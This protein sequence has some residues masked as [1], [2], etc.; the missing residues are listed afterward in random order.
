[1]DIDVASASMT[2]RGGGGSD[3]VYCGSHTAAL[4]VAASPGSRGLYYTQVPQPG[5]KLCHTKVVVSRQ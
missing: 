3:Y 4:R 2:K 1:M 5:V